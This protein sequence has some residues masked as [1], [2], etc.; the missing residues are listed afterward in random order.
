MRVAGLLTA[1]AVAGVLATCELA[2]QVH[3][4]LAGTGEIQIVIPGPRDR[5][6]LRVDARLAR[7]TA[8]LVLE[9]PSGG[10]F[11][12]AR[13]VGPRVVSTTTSTVGSAG[14]WTVHWTTTDAS[15]DYRLGW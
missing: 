7:G 15:G 1:F 8:V 3:G 2:A 5:V 6:D 4:E 13:L 10:R 12:L 14:Q 11:H 9:D